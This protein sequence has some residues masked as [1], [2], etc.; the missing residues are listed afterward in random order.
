MKKTSLFLV[1]LM[2][3]GGLA[4]QEMEVSSDAIKSDT[5]KNAVDSLNVTAPV[6]SLQNAAQKKVVPAVKNKV[7]LPPLEVRNFWRLM[8]NFRRE[9]NAQLERWDDIYL[10]I[11]GIRPNPDY[12][13]LSMPATYYEAPIEQAF[14]ISDWKPQIPFIKEN[15]LEQV[16]VQEEIPEKTGSWRSFFKKKPKKSK[17]EDYLAEADQI[18]SCFL[19]IFLTPVW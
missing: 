6:D 11:T 14:S 19:F 9:Y 12:Y 3:C 8:Q 13:K 17:L 5:L 15:V 7:E 10:L 18:D 2:V 4:A 16:S 1:L